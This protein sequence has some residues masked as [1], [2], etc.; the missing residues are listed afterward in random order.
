M[1]YEAWRISYQSSEQAARAAYARMQRLAAALA[2][3]R[4]HIESERESIIETHTNP[5]DDELD[6]CAEETVHD[7]DAVLRAID[8][9][10]A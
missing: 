1:N 6:F 7:I 2:L 9:A 3:S 4:Q 5:V 8:E 10:T